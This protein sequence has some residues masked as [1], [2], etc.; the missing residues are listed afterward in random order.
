[1][2]YLA[3]ML[4]CIDGLMQIDSGIVGFHV[5]TNQSKNAAQCVVL[6]ADCYSWC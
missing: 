1:M 5:S 3:T 2:S 4:Q 6:E